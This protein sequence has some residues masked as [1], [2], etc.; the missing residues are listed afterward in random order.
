MS[1]NPLNYHPDFELLSRAIARLVDGD[2][3][4]TWSGY[5]YR[6]TAPKYAN[7]EDFLSGKG[8]LLKGSRWIPPGVTRTVHAATTPQL[9]TGEALAHLTRYGIPAW[10]GMPLVLSGLELRVSCLLDLMSGDIRKSLRISLQRLTDEPW[11]QRNKEGE[12]ALTQAI[13]SAAFRA[14][15]EALLVPSSLETESPNLV[16]FPEALGSKSLLEVRDSSN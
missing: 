1:P 7:A 11:R 13:G 4:S 2:R 3:T 9:A 14:G 12:Q 16:V 6:F 15:V 8:A 10:K 5:G